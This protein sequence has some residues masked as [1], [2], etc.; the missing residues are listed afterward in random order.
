[1][2]DRDRCGRI[3]SCRWKR[4]PSIANAHESFKSLGFIVG[5]YPGADIER[6]AV[7]D[8]ALEDSLVGHQNIRPA[9]CQNAAH[10]DE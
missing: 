10:L 9:F 6:I 8:R 2:K 7:S 4:R 3:D 5:L 1:M